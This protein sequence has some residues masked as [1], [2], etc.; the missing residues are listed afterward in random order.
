MSAMTSQITSVSIIYSVVCSGANQRK[1]QSSASLA[2]VRRIHRWPVTSPHKE[3]VLRKNVFTWWRH[4]DLSRAYCVDAALTLSVWCQ[5]IPSLNQWARNLAT[6]HE[7]RDGSILHP[8]HSLC[9][10]PTLGEKF[11]YFSRLRSHHKT[12]TFTIAIIASC[13]G[14]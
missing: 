12:V 14:L 6:R 2:F 13:N 11:S 1:R 9:S 5:W 7:V 3:S 10:L 4:H 8:P